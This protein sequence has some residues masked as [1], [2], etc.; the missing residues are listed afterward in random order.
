[1]NV[2]YC[3]DSGIEKGMLL[4]ALSLAKYVKEPLRVYVM[5]AHFFHNGKEY[6]PVSKR[7][8]R[9][10]RILLRQ[11]NKASNAYLIDA[12]EEFLADL[13]K[14]NM[15]TRFTPCCMLRLYADRMDDLPDTILYLDNDVLCRKDPEE[16]YHQDIQDKELACVLD[17]YGRWLF[18]RKK[19]RQNYF[20]SGVLLL[21]LAKIR[22][23][24]LFR[25]CVLMCKA[26]KM[27][28]PDQTSLNK[29]TTYKINCPRSFNEQRRLHKNTIFQ[30]FTTSF[31]LFPWLH[32]VSVKP[33]DTEKMHNILKLH[34][35]DELINELKIFEEEYNE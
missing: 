34:E 31:R 35:Y 25:R 16:F 24:G 27:F 18:C 3:G 5:T 32:T 28:M 2:L 9:K 12:S 1:M 6:E 4:S 19:G 11:R 33:W 10:L 29:M 30:H 17:Y 7:C 8:L 13:P 14:A 22:E 23:T 21:N 26:K 20:N 15:D